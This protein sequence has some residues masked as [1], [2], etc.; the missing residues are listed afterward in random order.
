MTDEVVAE[1]GREGWRPLRNLE[2]TYFQAGEKYLQRRDYLQ[3][4]ESFVD[5]V[6]DEKMKMIQGSPM[7]QKALQHI[8]D[9][10]RNHKVKLEG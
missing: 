5:A 2:K 3:A 1:L 4:V 10:F 8:E 7:T 9:A 6:F